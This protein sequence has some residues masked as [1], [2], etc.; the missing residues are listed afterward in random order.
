MYEGVMYGLGHR[1]DGLIRNFL[2]RA[3]GGLSILHCTRSIP[4]DRPPKIEELITKLT[5]YTKINS[6]SVFNSITLPGGDSSGD[7]CHLVDKC[8]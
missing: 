6:L 3:H 8:A 4:C 7:D 5:L 2:E 1:A